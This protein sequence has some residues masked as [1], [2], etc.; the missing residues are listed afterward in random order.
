MGTQ[1]FS[2]IRFLTALIF[3]GASYVEDL[4]WTT[5]KQAQRRRRPYSILHLLQGSLDTRERTSFW[6][7]QVFQNFLPSFHFCT[8]TL[9]SA[10]LIP[11]VLVFFPTSL[12]PFIIPFRC[13]PFIYSNSSSFTM[14]Q[15][16]G[17][18]NIV[19]CRTFKML[20]PSSIW[21][22]YDIEI[23]NKFQH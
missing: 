23:R 8:C 6:I 7:L 2:K 9:H 21:M 14:P 17:W 15:I 22:Q 13:A 3:Q 10:I 19:P 16:H 12:C 18:L 5:I 20:I 1:N 11:V 4:V